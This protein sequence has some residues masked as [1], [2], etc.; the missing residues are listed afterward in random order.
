MIGPPMVPLYCWFLYGTFVL[1]TGSTAFHRLSRKFPTNVPFNW[2]VPDLVIAFTCT[3]D[4]RPCVA[5]KRLEMNWNSA[6][7]SLLYRDWLPVPRFE[8]TCRPSTLSWNSRT[9]TR[10]CT[11][12]EPCALV[13]LPGARDRKSTRLNSSHG[14]ISSAV[15]CL[16]KKNKI[17]G[18]LHVLDLENRQHGLRVPVVHE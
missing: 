1:S 3:P 2:L 11:G 16:K 18:R 17:R 15:F 4:E 14:Y 12:S 10:S 13:R 9:S 5:S 8:V 6:I 7:A